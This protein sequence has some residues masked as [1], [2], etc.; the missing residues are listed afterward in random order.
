MID[1]S[2]F[3]EFKKMYNVEK[4]LQLFSNSSR[5]GGYTDTL[6]I[7]RN[8]FDYELLHKVTK[9]V[10]ANLNNVID[11]NFYPTD[12]TKTSNFDIDPLVLVYRDLL[13][14]SQ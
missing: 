5:V 3:E 8:T 10:T 1:Q 14:L 12:K 7:L 2:K 9:V 13:M 11:I 6:N 4:M